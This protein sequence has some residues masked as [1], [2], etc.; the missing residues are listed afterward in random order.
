LTEYHDKYV[1]K[2]INKQQNKMIW[3]CFKNEQKENIKEDF[4]HK[5]RKQNFQEGEETDPEACCQ[6]NHKSR[7]VFETRSQD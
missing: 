7:N 5:N 2:Q 4:E 6:T 3:T 1:T